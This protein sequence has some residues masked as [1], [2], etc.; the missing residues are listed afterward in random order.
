MAKN[1]IELE[2]SSVEVLQ[3]RIDSKIITSSQ[4]VS[5]IVRTIKS[6]IQVEKNKSLDP[7]I[8]RAKRQLLIGRHVELMEKFQIETEGLNMLQEEASSR[9]LQYHVASTRLKSVQQFCLQR[10][11][12]RLGTIRSKTRMRLKGE[13]TERLVETLHA[14]ECE[15]EI[16]SKLELLWNQRLLSQKIVG[17][18]YHCNPSDFAVNFDDPRS[19]DLDYLL[20]VLLNIELLSNQRSAKEKISGEKLPVEVYINI[21]QILGVSLQL[22]STLLFPYCHE[23]FL[24]SSYYE[25]ASFELVSLLF[26]QVVIS[27]QRVLSSNEL[28]KRS[29]QERNELS[30]NNLSPLKGVPNRPLGNKMSGNSSLANRA[31][32]KSEGDNKGWKWGRVL[33]IENGIPFCTKEDYLEENMQKDFIDLLKLVFSFYHKYSQERENLPVFQSSATAEQW[34][35]SNVVIYPKYEELSSLLFFH[36]SPVVNGVLDCCYYLLE[37]LNR[38][39]KEIESSS[40]SCKSNSTSTAAASAIPSSTSNSCQSHVG[41]LNVSSYSRFVTIGRLIAGISHILLQRHCVIENNEG[42]LAFSDAAMIRDYDIQSAACFRCIA[43]VFRGGLLFSVNIQGLKLGQILSKARKHSFLVQISWFYALEQGILCYMNKGE[44]ESEIYRRMLLD[45]N[46]SIKEFE[47]RKAI[48]SKNDSIVTVKE[49]PYAT[50]Q[51]L[52]LEE[53]ILA[54]FKKLLG[55]PED[56]VRIDNFL[57]LT[58]LLPISC[59]QSCLLVRNTILE[60]I[61]SSFTVFC[62]CRVLNF[63]R[64]SLTIAAKGVGILRLLL[65]KCFFK[66]TEIERLIE[67]KDFDTF[68]PPKKIGASNAQS[69]TGNQPSNHGGS[70][71]F[72]GSDS[73]DS[74]DEEEDNNSVVMDDSQS[75]RSLTSLAFEREMNDN[76]SVSTTDSSSIA[77]MN[78]VTSTNATSGN[79]SNSMKNVSVD[80]QF[81][82]WKWAAYRDSLGVLMGP[83]NLNFIHLLKFIIEVNT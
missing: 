10:C 16:D 13:F 21:S 61:V 82:Q 18:G 8:P 5:N 19:F 67:I 64:H 1:I 73:D 55:K 78:N 51:G 74:E 38:V 76:A 11:E 68:V 53:M 49:D 62:V 34:Y 12:A 14:N 70:N 60:D 77:Q 15:Q 25:Q 48:K 33:R 71:G 26:K 6:H 79:N 66:R 27:F 72:H 65:R 29:E 39:S 81:G 52:P 41:Y 43:A 58:Q 28:L 7:L 4:A 36:G 31:N 56:T 54:N 50:L 42:N 83:K 47:S 3:K 44:T 30:G 17:P 80:K 37:Y 46:S 32:I 75:Q 2:A 57:H 35:L 69:G 45:F 20:L 59:R 9:M 23:S 63:H 40:S 22:L 24:Q